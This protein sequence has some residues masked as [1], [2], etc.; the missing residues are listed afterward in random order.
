MNTGRQSQRWRGRLRL[1]RLD[2][3][4]A[5]L[6]REAHKIVAQRS[7]HRYRQL[8]SQKLILDRFAASTDMLQSP[9]LGA[10][11]VLSK[12]FFPAPR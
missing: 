9:P 7:P 4:R 5:R 10:Q 8:T 1:L 6:R 12:Q 3:R 2:R 11:A